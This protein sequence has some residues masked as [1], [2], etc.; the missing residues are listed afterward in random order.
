MFI[1]NV[2]S[3]VSVTPSTFM[4]EKLPLS[5]GEILL[6]YFPHFHRLMQRLIIWFSIN[7]F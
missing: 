4:E 5:H 2:R 1:S 6:R 7:D 3:W